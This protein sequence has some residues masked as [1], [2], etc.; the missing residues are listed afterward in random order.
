MLLHSA[1]R[2][3]GCVMHRSITALCFI[4]LKIKSGSSGKSHGPWGSDIYKMN[5][6]HTMSTTKAASVKTSLE[7]HS[8]VYVNRKICICIYKEAFNS[9]V[10][11]VSHIPQSSRWITEI[12]LNFYDAWQKYKNTGKS[13]IH[14]LWR[15]SEENKRTFWTVHSNIYDSELQ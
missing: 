3:T 9:Y 13:N 4:S 15:N 12:K 8:L 11:R 5:T 14:S 2:E 10:W 6:V 1:S 7:T